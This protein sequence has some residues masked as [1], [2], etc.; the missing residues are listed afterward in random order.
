M[1]FEVGLIIRAF[2]CSATKLLRDYSNVV[3]IKDPN[4]YLIASADK[5]R[6]MKRVST[7]G[8]S[9]WTVAYGRRTDRTRLTPSP[10]P[11][12]VKEQKRKVYSLRLS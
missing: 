5:E 9:L 6:C 2:K 1:K 12:L 8:N 11:R 3:D 4:I 7:R 10:V